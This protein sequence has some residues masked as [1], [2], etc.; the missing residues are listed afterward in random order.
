MR[1]RLVAAGT[2]AALA[3]L[4]LA[5]CGATSS[6]GGN[7]GRKEAP[8][9]GGPENDTG[10]AAG[11]AREAAPEG[12]TGN[13]TSTTNARVTIQR[14]RILTADLTIRAKSVNDVGS[15]ADRAITLVLAA[16]GESAGDSRVKDGTLTQ[17]DVILKVPPAKYSETLNQLAKLGTELQ[18]S[19]KA[20][21][22]TDE[23]VDVDSRV[24]SQTASV[25]RIRRLLASA[26][27]LG[28]V[29]TIE[30]ELAKR[31][32]DLE[33]LK[34]R[35]RTLESQTADATITLH[36]KAPG[37]AA[38]KPKKEDNAGF[39]AGLS[40][41]WTAFTVTVTALVT[42]FGALLPFLILAMLVLAIVR[43]VL[44]RRRLTGGDNSPVVSAPSA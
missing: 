6:D 39:L 26:K 24:S 8:A 30:A 16:G 15:V 21:D 3:L 4:T 33:S 11:K 28:D 22:V 43:L 20:E 38:A 32:A 31:Q 23:V 36:V 19:A 37:A 17:A 42:V 14:A 9:N 12:S 34:A 29:V 5:G 18:R 35:Q 25:E 44:R 2:V 27:N 7:A 40:A 41:G 13:S 1:S 10:S